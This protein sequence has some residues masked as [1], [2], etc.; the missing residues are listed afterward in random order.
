[1]ALIRY[2]TSIGKKNNIKDNKLIVDALG[3]A[4]DNVSLT[5]SCMQDHLWMQSVVAS[6]LRQG[7]RDTLHT[8]I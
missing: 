3:V 4:Q 7:E 1:M 8:E 6:I 2:I 5:L